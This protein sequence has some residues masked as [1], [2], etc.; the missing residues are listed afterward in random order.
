MQFCNAEEFVWLLISETIGSI[1]K[2]TISFV[3]Q[4]YG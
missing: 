1:L 3:Q 2:N 4:I